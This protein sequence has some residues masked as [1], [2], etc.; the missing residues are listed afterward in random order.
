[1]KDNMW[2]WVLKKAQEKRIADAQVVVLTLKRSLLSCF[3]SYLEV[4]K[5]R[6]TQQRRFKKEEKGQ[7][8]GYI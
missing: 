5:T 6:T 4:M 8:F 3:A 1:M 2:I 7:C